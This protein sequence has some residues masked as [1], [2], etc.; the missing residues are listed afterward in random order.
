MNSTKEIIP[1]EKLEFS[2][3]MPLDKKLDFSIEMINAIKEKGLVGALEVVEKWKELSTTKEI[4]DIKEKQAENNINVPEIIEPK[5][6]S[7]VEESKLPNELLEKASIYASEHIRAV[8]EDNQDLT[9]QESSAQVLH[10]KTRIL[11]NPSIPSAHQTDEV[12]SNTPSM[13]PDAVVVEPG[14]FNNTSNNNTNK[15]L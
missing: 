11:T 3:E 13:Y 14:Y 2:T 8:V 5:P 15:M 1:E 12:R 4:A 10:A 7:I 6:I 9:S